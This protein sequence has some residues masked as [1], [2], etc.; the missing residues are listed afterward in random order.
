[1]PTPQQSPTTNPTLG[2][3]SAQLSTSKSDPSQGAPPDCALTTICRR[4]SRWSSRRGGGGASGAGG[5]G[6][7]KCVQCDAARARACVRVRA[8]VC[9]RTRAYIFSTIYNLMLCFFH[10]T[11]FHHYQPFLLSVYET[12]FPFKMLFH[13][14]TSLKGLI[15]IY[16]FYIFKGLFYYPSWLYHSKL[17]RV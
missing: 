2:V 14:H 3:F 11:C 12:N 1:M 6:W 7:V 8:R 9:A 13:H 17:L 5:G 10:A 4:R 16:I 15:T